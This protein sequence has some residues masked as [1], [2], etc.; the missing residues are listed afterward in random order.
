LKHLI[1]F[2]DFQVIIIEEK[3]FMNLEPEEWPVVDCLITF[4]SGGFP[5]SKMER[6]IQKVKPYLI[7]DFLKQKIFWNRDEVFSVL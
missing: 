4:Y 3:I 1:N 2:A 5:Y 7:N 6:Y